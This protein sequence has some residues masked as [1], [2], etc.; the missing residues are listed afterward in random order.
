MWGGYGRMGG[1]DG[2]GWRGSPP[3]LQDFFRVSENMEIRTNPAPHRKVWHTKLPLPAIPYK[4]GRTI[5]SFEFL[6][7]ELVFS[8][9]FVVT[10]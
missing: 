10:I 4:V 6:D 3:G 1:L 2:K 8:A 7:L 9:K 5:T